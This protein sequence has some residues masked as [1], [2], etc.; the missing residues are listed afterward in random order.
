MIWHK[1]DDSEKPNLVGLAAMQQHPAYGAAC[2]LWGRKTSWMTLGPRNAPRG[3]ALVLHRRLP[4]IGSMALVSRG[5]VWS[6][7]LGPADRIAATGALMTALRRH[8]RIVI[9]TPDPVAGADPL[10]AAGLLPLLTPVT[11]ACLSL[12][13]S[14]QDRRRRL[15]GKWRNRLLRAEASG[16]RVDQSDLTPDPEHWLLQA[17][18]RQARQR[19]YRRLAPEFAA[20]WAGA[21]RHATPLFV[22]WQGDTPVAALLFLL[23][24]TCA[25]YHIGWSNTDGRAASAHNLLMWHAIEWL[26]A[27]GCTRL[28]LDMI[29]TVSSPGLA[30]FKLG[31]GAV[32]HQLGQCWIDAPGA[33]LVAR[34]SATVQSPAAKIRRQ[35]VS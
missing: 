20:A 7:A 34:L 32:P 29:D 10:A 6:D 15:H 12:T 17:E 4:G 23:H 26:G 16:L 5:P 2:A 33:R 27:R 19:G 3:S 18:T 24:G 35:V 9:S 31:T 30:R 28:D 8:H 22:A 13:G 25:T 1:T 21:N 14:T 11:L